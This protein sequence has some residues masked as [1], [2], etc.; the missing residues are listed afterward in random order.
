[1]ENRLSVDIPIN[2]LVCKDCKQYE[3]DTREVETPYILYEVPLKDHTKDQTIN[4]Q[5]DVTKI[6]WRKGDN[7]QYIASA[8]MSL[9]CPYCENTH[10]LEHQLQ[11]P[12]ILLENI[13][14]CRQCNSKLRVQSEHIEFIDNKES[15]PQIK[16]QAILTCQ[17]CAHD[18][19]EKFHIISSEIR[20]LLLR[21]FLKITINEEVIQINKKTFPKIRS[22]AESI[23]NQINVLAIFANPKGSNPLRLGNEDRVIRECVERSKYRDSINIDIHHAARIDDLARALLNEEYRIAQ[24]SGHGTGK[25]LAFENE[26]GEV[27]VVPEDALSELLSAYSPPLECVLLNAC[28]SDVHNQNLQGIPYT[29]VMDGPISD[30]GATEFSRGFYDAIG[31]GKT[32]KFAYEE[33]CRRIKLKGL[34]NH[35]K[36]PILHGG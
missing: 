36:L 26:I 20:S 29:I 9:P 34:H 6:D 15:N 21:D 13:S 31:A 32:V 17:N 28:Y 35:G 30:E 23:M 14:S 8:I 33:G 16:I 3:S 2:E 22:K 18:E 10:T 19:N 4:V 1:M 27:F 5:V 7:E 24:F 12:V 25:G 11:A